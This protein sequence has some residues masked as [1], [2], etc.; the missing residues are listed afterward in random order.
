MTHEERAMI[1]LVLDLV[2]FLSKDRLT[3]EEVTARLGS[4]AHDPGVPMP[5]QLR[6]TLPGVRSAV[7]SR[8]PDSG[9]PYALTLEPATD[10]RPTVGALKDVLGSYKRARSTPE[11]HVD[12]IFPLTRVGSTWRIV[13]IVTV[14]RTAGEMDLAR[15]TAIGFRRDPVTQ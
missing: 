13:V 7:L 1:D 4:I 12:L 9:I 8:Y 10:S 6:P 15:T 5:L 11:M 14:D 2:L 3:V